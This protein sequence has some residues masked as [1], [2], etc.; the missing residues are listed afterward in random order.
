MKALDKVKAQLEDSKKA[1]SKR[2]SAANEKL[3][4]VS[5]TPIAR[6]ASAAAGGAAAGALDGWNMGNV[7]F[8]GRE[9]KGGGLFL[10][11]ALTFAGPK[12]AAVQAA[13]AG[14]IGYAAGAFVRDEIDR[15]L[16]E[17]DV[18]SDVPNMDSK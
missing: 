3:Q 9:V 13:A 5:G 6:V 11:A 2:I 4:A 12:N 16:L 1:A 7:E 14:M 17:G 10:G 8:G 18:T 15:M